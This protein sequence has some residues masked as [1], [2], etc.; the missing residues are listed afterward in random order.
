M[1]SNETLADIVAQIRAAAHIQNADSPREVLKFADRI[2]AAHK[3]EIAAKDDERLTI[4]ANYENVIAD[5]D[6]KI[7]ELRERLKIAEDALE[8]ID[9][10][11][12]GDMC[13]FFEN[14]HHCSA[15]RYLDGCQT[16]V[17]HAALQS[18]REKGA[19]NGK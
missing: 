17:A 14:T 8:K 5:K 11:C 18:I 9:N 6:T 3:R 7:A 15:C 12:D 19:N 1:A 10:M 2:A 4:V 16:G 13:K